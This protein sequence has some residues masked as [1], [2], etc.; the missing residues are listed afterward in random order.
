MKLGV[1]Y[2]LLAIAEGMISGVYFHKASKKDEERNL[3]L[4]I[5]GLWFLSSFLNAVIG[6]ELIGEEKKEKGFLGNAFSRWTGEK[7]FTV[8]YEGG[9]DDE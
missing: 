7:D 3:N 1:L 8:D 4:F 6:G 2:Y 9:Q 5:G